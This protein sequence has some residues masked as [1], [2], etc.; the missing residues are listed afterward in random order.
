[1][2][3]THFVPSYPESYLIVRIIE[4]KS[5]GWVGKKV[6]YRIARMGVFHR[7]N[8]HGEQSLEPLS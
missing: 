7:K 3:G 2:I 4:Q 6:C 8:S 1:M 5:L